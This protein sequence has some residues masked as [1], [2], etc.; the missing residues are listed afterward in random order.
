MFTRKQLSI[1]AAA[2]VAPVAACQSGR[3]FHVPDGTVFAKSVAY[4]AAQ[5]GDVVD[6]WHGV[7]VPD[8]YRWL[9][10]PDAPESRVWIEAQNEVTAT[11]L[12]SIPERAAIRDRA[13]ELWNYERYGMPERHGARVFYTRNDGLQNQS[14]LHVIDTP[15][16]EPRVLLDPN[17]LSEDGTIALAGTSYS[18][19][20]RYLA[21]SLAEGGSDWNSIHVRDVHTARDIPDQ[22]QWV[23][24]S[25]TAWLRDDSGFFYSRYDAPPEG[26]ELQG[27][28][29]FQKLYF[30]K[31]GTEQDQDRLVY[32]R[33]DKKE[34]GFI[35]QVTDDGKYLII[36]VRQGTDPKNAVF[37]KD[38]GDPEAPVVE[39]I[40]DWDAQYSFVGNDGP[41]FWFRT[42]L[43]APRGRLILVDTRRGARVNWKELIAEDERT[44][45]SVSAVGERF[46][47][48]YLED[49]HTAVA[50]HDAQGKRE[51]VVDLPGIGSARGFGGRREDRVTYYSF[52]SFTTP[53]V[54]YRYEIPSGK[55]EVFREPALRF[56]PAQ[57]ATEQVF[58]TSK[59]G[60][61]VPMFLTYKRGIEHDGKRPTLLYGY[62]GFNVSLTPS[63]SPA[64]LCWMEMGGIYALANIRGGGEYGE[65]WHQ[66]GTKLNKQNVFD[67][68]I[69]AA[70]WLIDNG[71]TSSDELA[72][73]GG[74][75]GGLLVGAC[76][77]Q[78]PEL[79]GAAIPA[80]GVLDM[81]RFQKFTIGWAWT[82][83]YGSAED[84]EEFE[85]LVAYSPYHNVSPKTCYPPTLIT[86]AD[87][88]DRVVPAHS[89][90]FAAA[91][92]HAQG[93][94]NP[95][96]IRIDVKAGHGAGKPT[97][98]RIEQA[99]DEMAFLVRELD[100]QVPPYVGGEDE[101]L[102]E[103]DK[104]EQLLQLGYIK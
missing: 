65:E 83:D 52:S 42:N 41:L 33:P 76:I 22:L 30:H 43:D 70:E 13:A 89:F 66:A 44:L 45:Q 48:T 37:Y 9:E 14:V 93:C 91:L 102:D 95:I 74:S 28:N 46:I 50:V 21:Y 87:H 56:D 53:S 61:R 72:I 7:R 73:N 68:F 101:R 49:A 15:G 1:L 35:A 54:I 8:P 78:R 25:N 100:M 90:K 99:A 6:D 103:V 39:L 38:L 40:A 32:E 77:T 34:W 85:A 3:G 5:R 84:A 80:V 81:L 71:Y 75:N 51:R 60:T 27:V 58:C 23:K 64:R 36:R 59:D 18:H 31:L 92:Q 94:D 11:Y 88:D 4:P 62:G 17:T 24:F 82:S 86:T 79:F 16:A 10:D 29:Y 57:Y 96:L 97:S 98:K 55:S 47:C 104:L 12:E 67:D 20:G 26:E 19:D 63:F 69:A 2:L